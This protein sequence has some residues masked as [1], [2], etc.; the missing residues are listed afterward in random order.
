MSSANAQSVVHLLCAAEDRAAPVC[1]SLDAGTAHHGSARVVSGAGPEHGKAYQLSP[2][3][4]LSSFAASSH[5]SCDP[6]QQLPELQSVFQK[7]S[8]KLWRLSVQSKALPAP[9]GSPP[10]KVG[11]A[12]LGSCVLKCSLVN[13]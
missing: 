4:E 1:G 7:T 11:I 9:A 5:S 10:S 3:D 6:L 13:L 2:A 8:E 12:C